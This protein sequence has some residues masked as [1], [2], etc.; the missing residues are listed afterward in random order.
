MVT[1]DGLIKEIADAPPASLSLHAV[2]KEVRN[3]STS[4][5]PQGGIVRL[6][7]AN[8]DTTATST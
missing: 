8:T 2:A 3:A 7:R 1:T 4:F 5:P 6:D